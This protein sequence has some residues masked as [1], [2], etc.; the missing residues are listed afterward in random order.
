MLSRYKLNFLLRIFSITILSVIPALYL[1][2]ILPAFVLP[3]WSVVLFFLCHQIQER[4][5]KLSAAIILICLSV[6][7]FFALILFF[8]KNISAEPFDI[9]YLRF[10]II[11]PFLILQTIFISVATFLFFKKEQYRRYEP[12]VFFIIFSIFFWG[13]GNFSMSVFEHP[14]YAVLFSLTFSLFEIIRLFLSFNFEKKQAGFFALFLP[15]FAFVMFFVLK[16]YNESASINHGGLLQPTLF[17]F[18]FSDY[19]KLQSEIKMSDDLVLVTH[20]DKNFSHNMLRRMYLSAWDPL[21][22]FY[23]KKAPSENT[24]I[25]YLPKGKK[26]ILH[27]VFSMREKVEQEYFFVNLSPS[28]FI[29]MDYPTQIIPYEIW[30][31]SKFNGGYKVSSDAIFDFAPDIYGDAFPSGND[32]EGLSK[33]DLEFYTKIDDESFKLV[34]QKAEEITGDIPDYLDKILAL[35]LYFTE[36][37]FRYSLKPG[38][39]PDGNQLKYFLTE[40]KKGYC[41]YFAFSYALMLRSVGIPSRVAVGFF[42]Q[43]DSEIMNYYPVRA[44]MAHAWVEVFFPFAGWISFDPTTSQLAEGENINIGMNAGG[45][46]FNSLLSEILEKRDEIKINEITEDQNDT[47]TIGSYIKQFFKNNISIF[48]LIV[49][50]SLLVIFSIYK[51]TPYLILK[52]SK[53]NRKIVLTAGKLFKKKKQNSET[54]KQMDAL[55]QKAK[56]APE[57]TKDDAKS[58]KDI[59]K[60][61]TKKLI[62]LLAFSLMSCILFAENI[63]NIIFE[64]DKAVEAE[65]W[66]RALALLQ[67]GIKRYPQND[68][69]FFKLGEIYHNK[70][71]YKPA[72]KI[73][74]KGLDIN[75]ENS[76]ILYYLSNCASLLNKYEEALDY[77]KR[78][79]KLVPDDRFAA[80]NYGWLCF[81]CRRP[82]DG[83]DFLLSNIARYGENLSVYNSLGTLYNEVFDYKKSKEFY[84]KAINEA[85]KL[86]RTYSASIYYYNKA[87]LESQFHQFDNAIED[88]KAALDMEERSSS[89][90]MI[91]EL[92]QRRNN[93][94]QALSAYV[95]AAANDDTPL[96]VLSIINVFLETGHI[97]KAEHYILNE[98]QNVSEEWIANYGLSVNEFKSNLYEIKKELY[99]RKYNFEKRRLT[100]GLL[101]WIKNLKDKINYKL[102]YK[103]YDAVYRIYSI[104]VASEYKKNDAGHITDTT[105]TL[106]TNTSYYHAFK[107]KGNKSLKYLKKSELIETMFI[108]ESAG[109]Y[110]ADRGVIESDLK[111]LNEGISKMNPEWEKT[112]LKE[113]YAEGIKIAKKSSQ[114]FYYLYLES[115]F[116]LNPAGFLEYDIEFPVKINMEIDKTEKIKISKKKMK[117][118]IAS[119]RFKEDNNSK[120]SI[121]VKYHDKTLYFKLLDKNGYTSYSKNIQVDKLDKKN[122][123]TAVNL[124]VK[125]IFTFKL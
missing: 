79:L 40:A 84:I 106:Y 111:M 18:D 33:E 80:S 64:A 67:D 2:E 47:L 3:V 54:V 124:L 119:S 76:S 39:A 13:Q 103:Y 24:Q 6:S 108:P 115:L 121:H 41:T 110:I 7:I 96:S 72:Y 46:E 62:V 85:K 35:Q 104:K 101:D 82:A 109:A 88:A 8:L 68:K 61:S 10:G 60:K 17:R 125:D 14:I 34:H 38:K 94:V 89:Y 19:L 37:D 26:N 22:G 117:K 48:R 52:F 29:A 57:C 20:F 27:K 49:I 63:D 15:F 23:E 28:S 91:G 93:F 83:I 53:N 4:K 32:E 51:T 9:L 45:E 123:K 43:P 16:N 71:L 11:I 81:K 112:A 12:I 122:F 99:I 114:S 87:I 69:L 58:A 97:E 105:N 55:I 1:F 92:E 31:S 116:D 65:N 70:Q 73:L 107:G 120:F 66:E 5:V 102:K 30:D 74:K 42:V 78:Y 95:S 56:F 98:L 75:P 50:L 118:I 86:D 44:N 90:M 77:I 59:L 36:G 21:K 25:T 113:L 100:L